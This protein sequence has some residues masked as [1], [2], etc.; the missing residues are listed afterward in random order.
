MIVVP[1]VALCLL[2]YT[3]FL[4]NRKKQEDSKTYI[5]YR[6]KIS[7]G[8]ITIDLYVRG[9]VSYIAESRLFMI[10][11]S[12]SLLF[13]F[14]ILTILF[15]G[16]ALIFLFLITFDFVSLLRLLI[17]ILY[18]FVPNLRAG[19]V[20]VL[21][22]VALIFF[23][24]FRIRHADNRLEVQEYSNQDV[25]SRMGILV[26]FIGKLRSGKT[27]SAS[28]VALSTE[29]YFYHELQAI[30]QVVRAY[31]PNFKWYMLELTFR[32]LYD[33]CIFNNKE[34][35]WLWL[36]N[37]FISHT[38]EDTGDHL[39][40]GY[41]LLREKTMQ[42]DELRNLSILDATKVYLS[43]FFLY[44][45]NTLLF[46]APHVIRSGSIIDP[47]TGI[48]LPGN[49]FFISEP[50]I[51]YQQ[52]VYSRPFDHDFFAT[53][54][55]VLVNNPMQL[56]FDGGVV[57]ISEADKHYGN[58]HSNKAYKYDD[59]NANPL[60]SGEI[61]GIKIAGQLCMIEFK[62]FLKVFYDLQRLDDMGAKLTNI[63][64]TV[65]SMDRKD[66]KRKNALM[67]YF[68]TP[69]LLWIV[70]KFYKL[71]QK[72]NRKTGNLLS[73]Y[74]IEWLYSFLMIKDKKVI[75][76]YGY[77]KIRWTMIHSEDDHEEAVWYRMDKKCKNRRYATDS[78]SSVAYQNKIN[79]E[80]GAFDLPNYPGFSVELQ[81]V[82][83]LT[84]NHFI[85]RVIEQRRD[86]SNNNHEEDAL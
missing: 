14:N 20:L 49:N 56:N 60:N 4:A 65:V 55:T 70:S 2:I 28:D 27:L 79:A 13:A 53:V 75:N 72:R 74:F 40:F 12:I 31:F 23:N 46:T 44:I 39:F 32:E 16:L 5:W 66:A 8:V 26:A 15:H 63:F 18:L 41:D 48:R 76:K 80:V 22:V 67:F 69:F 85:N 3:L 25:V 17:G 84:H 34:Q 11:I 61:E 54:K 58:Q 38:N 45:Q 30:M 59:P 83:D 7:N 47:E 19:A 6:K 51:E 62:C 10:L 42:Y 1:V 36:E 50:V 77:D 86:R 9:F 35:I 68:V 71:V 64:D 24:R 21:I 52:C 37:E 43:A 82:A 33:K 73:V 81:D 29:A 78:L 57:V